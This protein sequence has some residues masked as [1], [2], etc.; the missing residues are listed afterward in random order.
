MVQ[1]N[2]PNDKYMSTWDDT[3][4]KIK[5]AKELNS[6]PLSDIPPIEGHKQIANILLGELK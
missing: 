4:R 3:D 1:D 5:R 2:D 6:Q